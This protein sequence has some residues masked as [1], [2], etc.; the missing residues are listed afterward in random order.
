[1]AADEEPD[2]PSGALQTAAE[3]EETKT[4][5]D[6]VRMGDAGIYFVMLAFRLTQGLG[7][8]Y[9]SRWC[10]KTP[11]GLAHAIFRL[12]ETR[13]LFTLPRVHLP[14]RMPLGR[15]S[16]RLFFSPVTVEPYVI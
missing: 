10:V 6:L 14:C 4:F 13:G 15:E 11:W 12:S 1:M 2:S 9:P 3:E 7:T 5:K 8:S 16:P